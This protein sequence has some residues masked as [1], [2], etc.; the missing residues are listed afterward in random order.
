M[1]FDTS[2]T[3]VGGYVALAKE[4]VKAVALPT[5]Y[6]MISSGQY[7]NMLRV[8]ERLKGDLPLTLVLIFGLLYLNT[9]SAFKAPLVMLAVPFSAIGA[10]WLPFFLGCNVSIAVST[11]SR[12][13]GRSR[14][15]SRPAPPRPPDLA[16]ELERNT[17]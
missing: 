10:V 15:K 6:S 11:S 4:A 9:K 16:A 12:R 14:A 7:K 5:G 2:K 13:E 3:E 1:D 17:S 8:K